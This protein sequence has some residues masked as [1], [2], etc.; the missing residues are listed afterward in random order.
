M[1]I[2]CSRCGYDGSDLKTGRKPISSKMMCSK[3]KN[4][5]YPFVTQIPMDFSIIGTIEDSKDIK[6]KEE[7][8]K[9]RR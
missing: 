3:C 4:Y 7:I 2:E 5:F 1:K 9:L 6:I 8:D